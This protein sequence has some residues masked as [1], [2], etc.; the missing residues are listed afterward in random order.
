MTGTEDAI[1]SVSTWVTELH[2]LDAPMV[3]GNAPL[4]IG[5]PAMIPVTG[6][7]LKPAGKPLAP[8]IIGGV[9]VALTVKLK[10]T[11]C[12]PLALVALVIVT[13]TSTV[14]VATAQVLALTGLVTHTV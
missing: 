2:T 5:V 6:S 4:T 8:N 13:G 11:P 9:P 3:T 14:S 1:V 7:K 12:F 10:A